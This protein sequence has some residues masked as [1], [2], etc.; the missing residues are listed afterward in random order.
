MHDA[1][2]PEALEQIAAYFQVLGEGTRLRILNLLREQERNVGEL[3]Q[4][5]GCS[6]ANVSRHLALLAQH[7]LVTRSTRG[8]H[9]YFQIADPAIYELCELVCGQ[10]ERRYERAAD[11]RALFAPVAGR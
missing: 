8:T 10:I 3:A 4:L 11:A 7:G 5:C 1:M 6:S 2:T 9:V